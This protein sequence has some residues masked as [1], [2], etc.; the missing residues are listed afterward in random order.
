MKPPAGEVTGSPAKPPRRAGRNRT[1]ALSEETCAEL[2]KNLLRPVSRLSPAE[3]EDRLICGD[4]MHI[5]P[6]LPKRFA[7]L[8]ILDPPYNLDKA[9][10]G[11]KFS[12][13]GDDAYLEYL[14][15]WLTLLIP[16]LKPDASIY[17]CGDWRDTAVCFTALSRHFKV[18]NRI[19]WQREKGRGAARNW[20]NCTEDI[21]FATLSD[22]Y[23]F[24]V[25][26]V[27]QLRRVLAPYREDGL[28]KDWNETAAGNFRLTCPSNFWDDLTVP[29][30]SM[31]ENTDHPTQKPEKLVAKLILASSP[32]GGLVL[33]PFMGSGT[34]PVVAR[35]LGRRF[36]GIEI[37]RTYCCYAAERL[38]RAAVCPTI[39]GYRDGVFLERNCRLK[40]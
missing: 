27:K 17:L 9:F 37:D 23:Y 30:W 18:R 20:K 36:C 28:P 22:D 3:A 32:P 31:P 12:R 15:S 4:I 21:W 2:E 25:K 11:R 29:F 33:D 19:V 26:K 14:E 13:L 39:Q 16:T 5:A 40:G 7:D 38:R 34:T 35:K 24:D 6:L 1:L 10:N 8:L